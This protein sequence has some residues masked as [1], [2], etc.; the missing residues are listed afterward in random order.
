MTELRILS[1]VDARTELE[2]LRAVGLNYDPAASAAHT[3][4]NGWHIDDYRQALPAEIPGPP[5]QGGSWE[6]ARRLSETY[7]F[8]DPSL[9]R[10]FYDPRDDLSDR[11]ILLEV[12]FWGLRIYAGVR[13]G[14]V[15]DSVVEHV[16]RPARVSR[17]S[18]RTLEGH[19]EMGQIDYEVWKFLDSGEV[20]FRIHAVSRPAAIDDTIVALGYRIFGRK[21]QVEFARRAC[22]RMAS[23]TAAALRGESQAMPVPALGNDLA[24]RPQPGKETL[25]ERVFRRLR[26]ATPTG[27]N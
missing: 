7:E 26:R 23:L 25:F 6:T 22:A 18:Y 21:K 10:A 19:F 20:D 1:R 15:K 24:V 16:G 9:L 12:H 3:Q 2:R 8:V 5:I 13:A 17:W 4:L 14:G 27:G 11:T